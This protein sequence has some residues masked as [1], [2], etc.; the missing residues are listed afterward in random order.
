MRLLAFFYYNLS[1]HHA[2]L[3]E[4]CVIIII[5][6]RALCFIEAEITASINEWCM[7]L[8]GAYDTREA[9]R[10]WLIADQIIIHAFTIVRRLDKPI[11]FSIIITM[12]IQQIITSRCR[13]LKMPF[14]IHFLRMSYRI[15]SNASPQKHRQAFYLLSAYNAEWTIHFK[16]AFLSR[17][18]QHLYILLMKY[19]ARNK[20]F[21]SYTI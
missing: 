15:E 18:F 2:R 19:L 1:C 6:S 14:N 12:P 9:D 5:A 17:A 3:I 20:S 16:W 11:N 10:R 7:K 4:N 13:P 8:C 21:S